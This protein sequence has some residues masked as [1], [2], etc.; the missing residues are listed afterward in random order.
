MRLAAI[1][2]ITFFAAVSPAFAVA[3]TDGDGVPDGAGDA[4]GS[5]AFPDDPTRHADAD[6]DGVAEPGDNCP[7]LAN[8][9]QVDTDHDGLGDACDPDIDG[10]GFANASD[11]LPYDPAEHADADGDGVGDNADPDDDNDGVPDTSDNCR[12]AANPSQ[13]NY[14]GDT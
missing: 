3:D 10:D 9:T 8:P 13:A 4:N 1:L 6:A 11:A 12:T 7:G 5:D 14:D 2:L